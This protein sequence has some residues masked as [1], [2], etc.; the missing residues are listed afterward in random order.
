MKAQYVADEV[1]EVYPLATTGKPGAMRDVKDDDGN[2]IGE[3]IDP[4]GVADV[5]LISVLIKTAQELSA[6]V[7]ALESTVTALEAA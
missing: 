7:T 3:E 4:M 5:R 2:K 1:Y 6:K